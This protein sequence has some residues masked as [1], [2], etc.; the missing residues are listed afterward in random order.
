MYDC[1]QIANAIF[2]IEKGVFPSKMGE[3][4][5]TPKKRKKTSDQKHDQDEDIEVMYNIQKQLYFDICI[6]FVNCRWKTMSLI[7]VNI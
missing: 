6:F 4:K 3:T 5:T 7:C 2:P 1:V